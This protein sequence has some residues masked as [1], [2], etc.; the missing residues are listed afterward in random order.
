M[1]VWI[2]CLPSGLKLCQMYQNVVKWCNYSPFLILFMN[3]MYLFLSHANGRITDWFQ[4]KVLGDI[5]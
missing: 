3:N 4:K 1:C 5:F 2:F